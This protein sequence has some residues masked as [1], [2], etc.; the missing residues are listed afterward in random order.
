MGFQMIN[1][2]PVWGHPFPEAVSQITNCAKDAD[3]CALMA[4]HHVGYAVLIL[5]MLGWMIYIEFIM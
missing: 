5:S 2:I 3:Y 4:D 1:N